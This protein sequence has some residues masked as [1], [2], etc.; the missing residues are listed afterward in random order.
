MAALTITGYVIGLELIHS[1]ASEG[2]E[3]ASSD[4]VM[5]GT[6]ALIANSLAD[7]LS[8]NVLL[9]CIFVYCGCKKRT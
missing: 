3:K 5:M 9:C 7:V 6:L 8:P 1:S 2:V 4:P